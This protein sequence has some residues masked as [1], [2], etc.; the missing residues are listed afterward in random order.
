[1]RKFAAELGIVSTLAY[2]VKQASANLNP[3]TPNPSKWSNT[4][5]QFVNNGRRIV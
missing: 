2:S 5:K 4:L 1:M 3:L